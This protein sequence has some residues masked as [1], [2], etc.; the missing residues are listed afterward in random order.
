V[1]VFLASDQK[2]ARASVLVGG[3]GLKTDSL[4]GK[5]DTNY[6]IDINSDAPVAAGVQGGEKLRCD[7]TIVTAGNIR[8]VAVWVGVRR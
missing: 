1:G 3:R 7:V 2:D 8:A 6:L 4:V 5:V